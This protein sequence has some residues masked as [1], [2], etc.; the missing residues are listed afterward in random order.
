MI[1]FDWDLVR[2]V[3]SRG[4][5]PH[6]V[7]NLIAAYKSAY[8]LWLDEPSEETEELFKKTEKDLRKYLRISSQILRRDQLLAAECLKL[9]WPRHQ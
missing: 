5:N 9:Q 8:A 2:K 6:K 7:A 4:M 1:F 3:E